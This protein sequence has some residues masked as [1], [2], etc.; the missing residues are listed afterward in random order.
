MAE[1]FV[2]GRFVE[3]LD[4]LAKILLEGASRCFIPAV[5]V[6]IL[7]LNQGLIVEV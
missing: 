5:I 3:V 1:R 2:L 7:R 6:N 4:D